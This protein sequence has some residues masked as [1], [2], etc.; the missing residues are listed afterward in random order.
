M[1]LTAA[2]S[3]HTCTTWTDVCCTE[4]G[5]NSF[6]RCAQNQWPQNTRCCGCDTAMRTMR[7]LCYLW[8]CRLENS[9]RHDD[10]KWN[11][12]HPVCDRIRFNRAT[13][14]VC[15]W[16]RSFLSNSEICSLRMKPLFVDKNTGDCCPVAQLQPTPPQHRNV[17]SKYEKRRK[18]F[19]RMKD[20]ACWPMPLAVAQSPHATKQMR[21]CYS[22]FVF[23]PNH[24]FVLHHYTI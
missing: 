21:I 13:K 15:G 18:N 16:T 22:Q 8:G 12:V 14:M 19:S 3:T 10:C 1:A 24:I 4:L 9:S 17:R 20:I 2:T 6:G 7:L 5:R 11:R 23:L